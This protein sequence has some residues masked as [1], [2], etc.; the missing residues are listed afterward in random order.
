MANQ[1]VE[2]STILDRQTK[3]DV[4]LTS[5]DISIKKENE[6]SSPNKKDVQVPKGRLAVGENDRCA[7]FVQRKKR[8]CR[9]MV[10]PGKKFCGEHAIQEE[11]GPVK[12]G[13][14][15]CLLIVNL[16]LN[17][18]GNVKEKGCTKWDM[19]IFYISDE[20]LTEGRIKCP[21]DPNH[22]C[23]AK[24]LS[25]HLK[26]C[27]CKPEPLPEFVRIGA[28]GPSE[29]E[30]ASSVS[31]RDTSDEKLL[32]IIGLVNSIYDTE[33][34]VE[35]QI[36]SHPIVEEEMSRNASFFGPEVLKHLIQNS[37]LLGNLE[38]KELLKVRKHFHFN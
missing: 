36:K 10:K 29:S 16:K 35:T 18:V 9:M 2:I 19:L 21:Y 6:K 24:K 1:N 31:I 17:A 33:I 30:P 8:T 3:E 12:T 34:R 27:P 15:T 4:T 20:E 26:K 14:Q 7:H 32:E 5:E 11:E 23:D 37:S 22:T 25:K 38:S 28:N 13:N